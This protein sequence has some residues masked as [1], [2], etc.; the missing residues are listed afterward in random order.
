MWQGTQPTP[1]VYAETTDSK[2][3]GKIAKLEILKPKWFP[4]YRVS[5]EEE[6]M[7]AHAQPHSYSGWA[8]PDDSVP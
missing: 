6:T 1:L 8:V 7:L 3:V 4:T 2:A 5:L